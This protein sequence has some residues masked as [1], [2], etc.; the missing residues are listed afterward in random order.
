MMR[1]LSQAELARGLTAAPASLDR[2]EEA[3]RY[4]EL[5]Q[6][7]AAVKL[8]A[9]R[10]EHIAALIALCHAKAERTRFIANNPDPQMVMF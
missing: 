2:C 10:A 5:R 6:R 1:A 7:R 9:A 8:D 3:V 4:A